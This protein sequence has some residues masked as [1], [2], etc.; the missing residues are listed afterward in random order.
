MVA[1]KS[2]VNLYAVGKHAS[3]RPNAAKLP[4]IRSHD[5]RGAFQ[6]H[7][8]ERDLSFNLK[9]MLYTLCRPTIWEMSLQL[10][11]SQK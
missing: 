5:H 9:R 7:V 3:K 10:C 2:G 11:R 8:E 4:P 1:D 6:M